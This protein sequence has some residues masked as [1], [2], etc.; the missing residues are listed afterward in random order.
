M[1]NLAVE[2]VNIAQPNLVGMFIDKPSVQ[3]NTFIRRDKA[4]N[5]TEAY[6][7]HYKH[8]FMYLCHK[9]IEDLTWDDIRSI[10]VTKVKDYRD[11]LN[12]Q[13]SASTI[14]QR[15]F[16][17]KALWDDFFENEK[18]DKNVFDLKKLKQKK[19][20]YD[21]LTDREIQLLYQ[22]CLEQEYKS[23]TKQLY[24]EFLYTTGL[25]KNKAQTIKVDDIQRKL[26]FKTQQEFWVIIVEDKGK[27]REV[28]ITD[29][30]YNRLLNNYKNEGIDD[31]QIFHIYNGTIDDTLKAFCQKYGIT[32]HIV[33][34]SIKSASGDLVY[35]V[36][37]DMQETANH[38][39]HT[40][41]QT[42]FDYYTGK[43]KSYAE[44]ASYALHKGYSI[45][46]LKGL[47][48]DVLIGLIER[49]TEKQGRDIVIKLGMELEKLTNK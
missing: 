47:G 10:T 11:K 1:N 31:G 16:A 41:F 43:N 30:F 25:R 44:Q 18:V 40:N 35:S 21:S 23:L 46:M 24:F 5:T 14:N 13:F 3:I 48:E 38:L 28:S 17:A 37:H 7:N 34:H 9:N 45:D 4:Q 26:D 32:R 29:E 39:G 20:P 15:I 22:F 42:T 27:D 2:N 8:I 12:G 6:I 49:Y 19:N 36:T 33:Q